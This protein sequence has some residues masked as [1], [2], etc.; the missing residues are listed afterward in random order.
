MIAVVFKILI[1]LHFRCIINEIATKCKVGVTSTTGMA[2]MQLGYDSTTIHHWAGIV[3]GR[4]TNEKLAELF[5]SDDRYQDAK[6]RISEAQ[7]LVI[8]EIGMLFENFLTWWNLS[9]DMFEEVKMCLVDY[10]YYLY[11]SNK[12][13]Y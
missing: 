13:G 9:A 4:F 11:Y 1:I 10:R 3:D 6:T 12:S 7:V 5:S 2:S 8:D